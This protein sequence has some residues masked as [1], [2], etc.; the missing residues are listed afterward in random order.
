[1]G[2]KILD[3]FIPQSSIYAIKA[4]N[5]ADV[6]AGVNFAREH[7]L[8]LVVKGGAHSYSGTSNAPDSLLIWTRGMN[9][10]DL[11]D[12]FIE[13]G[14]IGS[15]AMWI[16]VYNT[17]TTIGGRYV[18]GGGCATVGVAGFIQAGGFGLFSK[19][20]GTGAANLL[21]AEV[22][23]A[24]GRILIVNKYNYSDL[25]WAIKGGGGP[26][27]GIVT[28]ITLCTYD[29]TKF[30][31]LSVGVVMAK[32]DEAF[33]RLITQFI[34]FY[35]NS[36]FNPDWGNEI[37]VG[38]DNTLSI[39][40]ACCDLGSDEINTVWKPF[41]EWVNEAP[42]NLIWKKPFQVTSFDPRFFWDIKH[43]PMIKSDSRPGVPSYHGWFSENQNECGFHIV[44][45]G[46]HKN[47]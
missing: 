11:H 39:S 34:E 42:N 33:K 21:E 6:V 27:F 32:T 24:D 17:V 37:N 15:G 35:S 13:A 2:P 25:F 9:K 28:R 7:N 3:G 4:R 47:F 38:A 30:F 43:N 44:H 18:Q 41:L 10:V 46:Y 12:A 23:A 1:M 45:Y 8:R 40:L 20:F 31:G 36:L 16:D 29:L 26:T 14:S 19:K 22:V 5:T